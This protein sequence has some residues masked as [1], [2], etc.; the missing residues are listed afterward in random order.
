MMSTIPI[1]PEYEKVARYLPRSVGRP[2]LA[3]IP[4]LL[5]GLTTGFK[6][7]PLFSVQKV[8]EESVRLHLPPN[9]EEGERSPAILWLHG[10]GFIGGAPGQDDALCR[11]LSDRLGAVVAAARYPL[12]PEHTF[13][14]AVEVAH[15]ALVW[16]AARDDV[17][18]SRIAI[19]GASAGGGLAAQ[20]ALLARDRGELRPVFQALVYPM[21]DDRTAL[22]TDI[23]E[24]N[25]RLWNNEANRFGWTS[26]LGRAPGGDDVDPTAAPARHQDLAGLPPAWIGVGDLDLFLDED[27]AYGEALRAAGVPCETLVIEGVFHGFD[28]ILADSSAT[29]R[30]RTSMLDALA[31][32]LVPT[33]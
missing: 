11:M 4:R 30:F 5:E 22:R 13:P 12:S 14:A 16:L 32:A 6:N 10:G 23:D 9:A 31:K 7:D 2:W 3:R 28:G 17:D 27:I 26:Y 24:T 25:F 8:G 33:E 29:K 21:L 15:E 19:A 1:D 18:A 20:L